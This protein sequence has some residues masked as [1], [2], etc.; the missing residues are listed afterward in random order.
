MERKDFHLG[1]GAASLI[2]VVVVISMSILGL[3]S[4]LNVRSDVRLTERSSAL[5][6]AQYDAAVQAERDLMLLDSAVL[7]ARAAATEPDGFFT[8]LSSLLPQH[9]SL[10]DDV[11]S[12]AVPAG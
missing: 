2:L 9:M 10:N 11:V 4:V 6:A 8:V 7:Q 1:P 5:I 3:L 12:W